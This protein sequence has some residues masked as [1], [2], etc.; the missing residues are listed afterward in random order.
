MDDMPYTDQQGRVYRYGEFFPPEFSP[1]AYNETL[2]ND[3]F[4]LTKEEAQR[5]GY[6]WRDAETREFKTT[7][8]AQNLPDHIKDVTD[9][10]LKEVIKC[11][12]C[13]KA[14][15]LIPMELE[16]YRRMT[17]PIPH[18][19]HNCR[20]IERTKYRNQPK[21]YQRTCQCAG[22]RSQNDAYEN[23]SA[24]PHGPVACPTS[25]LTSYP[26]RQTSERV[27]AGAPDRPEIVYCEQCYQEEI[28]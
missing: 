24:H 2:A 15:R 18:L 19:C 3:F 6:A 16:F 14:Y 1:F 7:V 8:D 11:A 26:P 27:E 28:V 5:K 20:F 23:Q 21:F 25:F 22:Q 12:S 4:P 10:I 13:A 17:L 9:D